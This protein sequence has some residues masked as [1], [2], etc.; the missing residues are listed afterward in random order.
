MKRGVGG[1][2]VKGLCEFL[3]SGQVFTSPEE[4]VPF[5]LKAFCQGNID[6]TFTLGHDTRTREF[7]SDE[8][9]ARRKGGF[10]ARIPL[11]R[12]YVCPET[13]IL[14]SDSEQ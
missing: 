9:S 14:D 7:F 1:V 5:R 10:L 11:C 6:V 12:I 4:F 3:H 2:V 13:E 8:V